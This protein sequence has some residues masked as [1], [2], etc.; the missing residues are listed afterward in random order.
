MMKFIY[1]NEHSFTKLFG[2]LRIKYGP[3]KSYLDYKLRDRTAFQFS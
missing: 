2:T 3:I 1:H